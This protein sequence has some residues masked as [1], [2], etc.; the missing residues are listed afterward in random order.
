MLALKIT[1][2]VAVAVLLWLLA[3]QV[4]RV[5]LAP[6]PPEE[7]DPATL[8]PVDLTYECGVCGVRV[9]MTAAPGG[10][11]PEA[12]RHCREDMH[13]VAGGG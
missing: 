5:L 3:V 11:E 4:V 1:V 7:P 12:P 13:L 6:P 8:R 2:A 9:H 10:A